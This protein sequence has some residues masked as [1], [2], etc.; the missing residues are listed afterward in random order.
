MD[1]E[2]CDESEYLSY[3]YMAGYTEYILKEQDHDQKVYYQAQIAMREP[4]ECPLLEM[5]QI[6]RIAVTHPCP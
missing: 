5:Q 1:R 4:Y 3:L 2:I 6:V